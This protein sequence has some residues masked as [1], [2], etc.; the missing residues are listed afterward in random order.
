MLRF[1]D[2]SRFMYPWGFGQIHHISLQLSCSVSSH[3]A[4]VCLVA[5]PLVESEAGVDQTSLLFLCKFL[6][7]SMRQEPIRSAPGWEQQS[8]EGKLQPH[9]HSKARQLSTQLQNV[10]ILRLRTAVV[11]CQLIWYQKGLKEG[12]GLGVTFRPDWNCLIPKRGSVEITRNTKGF[13]ILTSAET[14]Y[15]VLLNSERYAPAKPKFQHPH[16]GQFDYFLCPGS[17]ELDLC[18][19]GVGRIEPEVS[20]FKWFLFSWRRSR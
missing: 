15:S 9:F 10:W 6:L 3:F 4:V 14:V 5:W 12:G 13:T 11:I 18:L 7:I 19:R 2:V 17:G 20:S 1:L 8:K 16:P